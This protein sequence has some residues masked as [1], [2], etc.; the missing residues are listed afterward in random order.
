M[1]NKL[2]VSKLNVKYAILHRIRAANRVPTNHTSTITI[3]LGKFIYVVGNK[4]LF[5]YGTYIFYQTIKHAGTC[6]IKMP[7]SFPSLICGIILNQ[8]P[9]ILSGNDVVCK[10][11]SALTL[12]FKLFSGKHVPDIVLTSASSENK[13]STKDDMITELREACKELDDVIRVSSARKLTFE[14]MIKEL[15]KDN[16]FDDRLNYEEEDSSEEGSFGSAKS[17]GPEDS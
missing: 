2:P 3:G 1:K 6:A 4:K 15:Q 14:K 8:H 10:R 16:N 9:G 7:I 13:T 11:E 17:T 5:D 12:H